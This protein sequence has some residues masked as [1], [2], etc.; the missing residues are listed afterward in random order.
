MK[1]QAKKQNSVTKR[2]LVAV[3]ALLVLGV[4]G[5]LVHRHYEK[6]QV[7]TTSKEVTAQNNYTSGSKR[8]VNSGNASQGGAVDEHGQTATPTTSQSQ[9]AT[10]TSGQITLEN[11]VANGLLQS[12]D[13]IEGTAKVPTVQFR[14]VDTD[15]GVIAQGQL[16]V[17][18]GV[19]AG[20]LEFQPQ[21]TTGQLDIFSYSSSDTEINSINLPVQLK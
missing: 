15:A 7:Q 11:P 21:A 5:Y 1:R 17:V 18:N 3:V 13:T 9:W 19:F 2:V 12:G 20:K 8:P 10:S 14:L 16:T 4:A 6:P